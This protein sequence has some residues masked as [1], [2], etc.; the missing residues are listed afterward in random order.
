MAPD[1]LAQFSGSRE[2]TISSPE[3]SRLNTFLA[4][5][6]AP[7]TSRGIRRASSSRAVKG[8]KGQ[9]MMRYGRERRGRPTPWLRSGCPGDRNG[10][11]VDGESANGEEGESG[12][13]EHDDEMC[14][15]RENR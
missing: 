6:I 15:E 2:N 1:N 8:D 7:P 11:G 5:E 3:G 12:F 4:A 10:Y 14:R 13:G 9:V